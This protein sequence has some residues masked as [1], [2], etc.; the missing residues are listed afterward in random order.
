MYSFRFLQFIFSGAFSILRRRSKEARR[1]AAT[2][3]ALEEQWG[4]KL[5]AF[6]RNK[7]IVSHSIYNPMIIDSF[8]NLY[9]RN[10]SDA[11]KERLIYYFICSSLLDNFFDRNELS[12][13]D[14][15]AISFD[16]TSYKPSTFDQQLFMHC[17]LT[18]LNYVQNKAAYLEVAR[19]ELN[20][21]FRSLQQFDKATSCED[22]LE[23]MERKGGN[24]VLLCRFYL[25]AVWD[26]AEARCWYILGEI[27]QLT[28]DLFD[29]H[30]D[31]NDGVYTVANRC[32]SAAEI[33]AYVGK[34]MDALRHQMTLVTADRS[35]KQRLAF[36]LSGVIA[37]SL[38]AVENL[39]RLERLYPKLNLSTLP[40]RELI[41]DMEKPA[42][43][44]KW[45]RYSFWVGKKLGG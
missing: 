20:A 5:D 12:H 7:I 43:I 38:I 37:F 29:I 26:E 24:A 19:N 1:A 34:K 25:D 18:L 13:A 40:R 30:K 35:K 41:I 3:N 42:N 27:I 23:I 44:I 33:D 11:E 9:G 4:G 28:N 39:R 8:C 14:I 21:Q 36:F 6:T 17:H 10:S 2:L 22:L 15:E 16:T 31:L 45:F 32:Y